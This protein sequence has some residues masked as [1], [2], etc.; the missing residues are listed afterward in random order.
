MLGSC[1]LFLQEVQKAL[2]K[3]SVGRTTITISHR[4]SFI[5]NADVIIVMKRGKIVEFGTHS[6][7]LALRGV[8]FAMYKSQTTTNT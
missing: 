6:Q 7:L 1:H 5:R 2:K 8:Y 3:A 4:F